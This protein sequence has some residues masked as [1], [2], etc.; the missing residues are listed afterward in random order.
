MED[1][2][3]ELTLTAIIPAIVVIVSA[4]AKYFPPLNRFCK[5]LRYPAVDEE[6]EAGDAGL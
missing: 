6:A 1:C 4:F 5:R 2:R 3:I